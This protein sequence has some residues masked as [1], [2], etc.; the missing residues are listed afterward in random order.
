[1]KY[2]KSTFGF[3]VAVGLL[4]VLS[5]PVIGAYSAH[6]ED[7]DIKAF[8][9]A[10][11][12]A[13]GTKLDNCFLCHTSGTVNNK[14]N[15]SCDYCH[16]VYGL[17]APHG[18]IKE[19]LN[20][21]GL[22][23]WDAGR[24]SDA[25]AL[26][27]DKDSDNDG[28]SNKDEIEALRLPG[29]DSDYPGVKEANAVIFSRKDIRNMP[30]ITQFFAVDTAKSGDYYANYGGVHMWELLQQAGIREDATDIT[31]YAGDGFSKNF[32]ISAV[33]K[34]YEAGLFFTRFPWILWSQ[35]TWAKECFQTPTSMVP[36]KQIPGQT[37]YMLAYER[38]GFPLQ[39]GKM[40]IQSDGSSRL[41]GEG[42]YRFVSPLTA[43]VV[44]DRSQY[45]ID[46]EDAPYP[47]NPNRPITRNGDY[48]IKSVVAIKVTVAGEDDPQYDWN[49]SAWPHLN[50]G[51]LVVYGAIEPK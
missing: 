46:R 49:S 48:C 6:N 47:Y 40:S 14:K 17:K 18:E 43:P 31:V 33:K 41:N 5:L 20:S 42:P 22:A 16:I 23:Y 27:A 29:D 32:P 1:M 25:F 11:P 24:N 21:F 9:T 51:E 13:A 39:P 3:L 50:N 8:L 2:K 37:C 10:Y 12:N 34:D 15:D 26:I 4:L 38:E 30:K 19:T 36:G 44:P 7:N 45:A 28:V 35:E